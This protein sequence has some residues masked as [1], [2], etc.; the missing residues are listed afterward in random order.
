[1]NKGLE[2]RTIQGLGSHS[3]HC[4]C[5][6]VSGAGLPCHGDVVVLP[7]GRNEGF[8]GPA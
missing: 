2:V 3:P 8:G 4:H 1:M 6:A 5:R 7:V